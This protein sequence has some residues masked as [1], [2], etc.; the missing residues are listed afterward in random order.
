MNKSVMILAAGRGERMGNLTKETP[1]PLLIFKGK[2]LIVWHI[3]KLAAAGFKDI[4]INVSYLAEKIKSYLANG[5]QWGV[6][7]NFSDENPVLETAGG[8]KNALPLL[9][10]DPFLVINSDIYSDMDY[11]ELYEHDLPNNIEGFLFFVK[12]PAHNPKG[13]FLLSNDGEVFNEGVIKKTFSGVALY[14]PNFF[15]DLPSNESIKLSDVLKE[16]VAKKLIKG[17]LFNGLWIDIGTPE[18]LMGQDNL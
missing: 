12:N 18:R 9:K 8:I 15:Y 1:K 3:E 4:V 14:R 11:A 2:P 10:S 17:K 13:D 5:S 6:Q 16:K 7:I